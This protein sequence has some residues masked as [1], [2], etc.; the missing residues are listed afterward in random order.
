MSRRKEKERVRG[1]QQEKNPSFESLEAQQS[2]KDLTANRI[3]YSVF[4]FNNINYVIFES[5]LH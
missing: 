1:D 4:F 3:L 5:R 2:T